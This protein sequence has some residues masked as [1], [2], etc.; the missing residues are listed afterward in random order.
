MLAP[1]GRWLALQQKAATKEREPQRPQ[2]TQSRRLFRP[3]VT[4]Y[5][6]LKWTF[7]C[8]R[9]IVVVVVRRGFGSG[10]QI[11]PSM[12]MAVCHIAWPSWL[13]RQPVR[14]ELGASKSGC[15]LVLRPDLTCNDQ[16]LVE[17]FADFRDV[18][19]LGTMD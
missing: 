2:L 14:F 9:K 16:S 19:D 1:S 7:A 8:L 15:Y 17:N 3:R 12:A 11:T 10:L 5:I 4:H 18:D 13:H 6:N